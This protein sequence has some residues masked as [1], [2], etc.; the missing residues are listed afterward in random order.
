MATATTLKLP[1]PLKVRIS[2]AAEAAGKTPHAFMI[3]AL[4]EQTERDE[5]RRDF[6]N[7]AIAA[8]KETTETGIT[9]DANEVHAY[10]RARISGKSRRRP[11]Q[12]KR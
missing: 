5:R 12:T 10:L 1:E 8:E 2:A 9:Y 7:A 6:L 4:A 3:E 11:K